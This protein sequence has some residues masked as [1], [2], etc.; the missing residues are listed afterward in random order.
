MNMLELSKGFYVGLGAGV[1]LAASLIAWWLRSSTYAR[2]LKRTIKKIS[3][4]AMVDIVVPDGLDGEIQLDYLLLT[5][6]GLLVLDIKHVTGR[7][8]GGDNMDEWTVID[9]GQRFTFGN[10]AGPLRERVIAIKTLLSDVPVDGR[11]V[12]LG[13]VTFATGVPDCVVSLQG[14]QDEF[15][16]AQKPAR[17]TVSDFLS[18]WDRLREIATSVPASQ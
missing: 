5:H 7:L 17:G 4:D 8:Y 9:R 18:S 12:V 16:P 14:L 2:Q 6:Q 10:P 13:D 15:T 11:V 3:D 1:V